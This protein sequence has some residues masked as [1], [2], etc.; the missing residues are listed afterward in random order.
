MNAAAFWAVK[1]QQCGTKEKLMPCARVALRRYV[2]LC[3]AL[4]LG[5]TWGRCRTGGRLPATS[6]W[7]GR[8][9]TRSLLPGSGCR[10]TSAL[11]YEI[12]EGVKHYLLILW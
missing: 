7:S 5:D 8:M 12:D 6:A 9:S 3:R 2:F 4:G 11:P 1:G 10:G